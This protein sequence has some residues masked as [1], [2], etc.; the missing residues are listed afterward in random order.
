MTIKIETKTSL[1]VATQT[2]GAIVSPAVNSQ[3]STA[4]AIDKVTLSS[5]G[6]ELSKAVEDTSTKKPVGVLPSPDVAGFEAQAALPRSE[7]YAKYEKAI[8]SLYFPTQ[9]ALDR[10]KTEVPKS[11]DPARLAQAERATAYV[12][13]NGP[14]PF[15][16]LSRNELAAIYYDDSGR[17]TTNERI[18]ANGQMQEMD[19]QYW[20]PLISNATATGDT[21]ALLVAG[22]AAYDAALPMEK[23][24]Y[25]ADYRQLVQ[26]NLDSANNQ[27]KGPINEKQ[28]ES[29]LDMLNALYKKQASQNPSDRSHGPV[30][31]KSWSEVWAEL[32]LNGKESVTTDNT[33]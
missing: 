7:L 13:H 29:L 9:A 23:M 26:Q 27:E 28:K 3:T 22:L 14:R 15:V 33:K 10:S 24:K 32:A 31:T 25:P 1:D 8:S 5:E 16:G 18:A 6:I 19:K 17:Y 30:Q 12:Y 11:D 20:G 2:V 4:H 21:R